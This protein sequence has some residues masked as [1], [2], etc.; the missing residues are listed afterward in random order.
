M[1]EHYRSLC[2]KNYIKYI[3]SGND[4]RVKRYLCCLRGAI[5]TLAIE[6]L[7]RLPKSDFRDTLY[8]CLAFCSKEKLDAN[9]CQIIT[10]L[11]EDKINNTN[12]GAIENIKELD[13]WIEKFIERK[14]DGVEKRRMD[15]GV[16]NREVKSIVYN[17]R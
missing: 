10:K 7:E 17:Q 2:K 5:N 8:L 9:M 4:V 13:D 3:K 6:S 16:V 1:V 14:F 15:V 12:M 11:V